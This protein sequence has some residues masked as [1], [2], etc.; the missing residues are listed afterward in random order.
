MRLHSHCLQSQKPEAEGKHTRKRKSC[1]LRLE[2]FT[3]SC[4]VKAETSTNTTHLQRPQT[5]SIND[6]G[7]AEIK[8]AELGAAD[9]Y[10]KR[11]DPGEMLS[12]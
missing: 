9:K 8:W 3:A 10:I 2:A 1:L 7:E 12:W 11:K 4:K 6:N 5:S